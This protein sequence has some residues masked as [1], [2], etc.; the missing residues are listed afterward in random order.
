MAKTIPNELILISTLPLL[1]AKDSSAIENIITTHDEIYKENLFENFF[2]NPAAKE[3]HRYALAMREGFQLLREK[4][5]ITNDLILK[6][7]KIIVGNNAGFRK[8]PGTE[9]KNQ[10]SGETIY[11]PPQDYDTIIELMNNLIEYINDD[12]LHNVDFLIKMSIIHFQFESIHPFY[13]GNGRTGRLINILYLIYKKLID[14]PMLYLSS[15]I[16]RTKYDYYRLLQKVRDEDNW[17]EWIIYMLKGVELTSKATIELIKSMHILMMDY[18]H[19]IRK[20]YKFYSQDLINNLF[21]H[22]YT[23]IEFIQNDLKVHR[24]TAASYLEK[25]VEGGFLKLE[26][27]GRENF[28]INEPLFELFANYDLSLHG[29]TTEN[30]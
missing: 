24:Q 13:D 23:K 8:L 25:L 7:Q 20:E 11:I 2:S 12:N 5:L 17:E 29:N 15:Y 26:K 10:N 18:K 9:L 3:V 4:N 6:L 16:I 27:I 21:K 1:E 14:L 19:R 22:P 28:Y 30:I